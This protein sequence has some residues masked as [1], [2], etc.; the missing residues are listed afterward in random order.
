MIDSIDSHDGAH[1]QAKNSK[2]ILRP[3]IDRFQRICFCFKTRKGTLKIVES[4]A[5]PSRWD[6]YLGDE[7]IRPDY[8]SI[9]E[10]ASFANR[11]DFGDELLDQLLKHVAV[12]DDLTRWQKCKL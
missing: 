9:Q 3:H 4:I 8:Q 5:R 7:L 11:S 10:A 1:A 2:L 12:P 6:L